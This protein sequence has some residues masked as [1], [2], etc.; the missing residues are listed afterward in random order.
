MA[1][2][3]APSI[4]PE[5]IWRYSEYDLIRRL[6]GAFFLVLKGEASDFVA[7]GRNFWE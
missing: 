2:E 1:T 3:L 5:R 7:T 6:F 4:T